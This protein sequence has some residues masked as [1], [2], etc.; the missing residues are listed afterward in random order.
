M[1]KRVLPRLKNF[2]YAGKSGPRA[3][4]SR[5]QRLRSS[6]LGLL[7]PNW[8]L[9]GGSPPPS[10]ATVTVLPPIPVGQRGGGKAG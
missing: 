7:G 6:A 8:G 3:P 4:P 5:P 9:T 1:G 2:K 10:R